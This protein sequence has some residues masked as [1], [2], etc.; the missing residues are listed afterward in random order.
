MPAEHRLRL[1]R[2]DRVDK[3]REHS[4]QQNQYQPIEVAAA[5]PEMQTCGLKSA[6]ADAEPGSR[7][8]FAPERETRSYDEQELGQES[9]HR[10]FQWHSRPLTSRRIGF[11]VGTTH[12]SLNKRAPL[13]RPRQTVGNR[14]RSWVGS[15]IYMFGFEFSVTTGYRPQFMVRGPV[16]G[17]SAQ[18]AGT[19]ISQ[20][21]DRESSDGSRRVGCDRE[22]DAHELW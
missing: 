21:S 14:F 18:F 1:D 8:A 17:A 6:P 15:I 13:F 9:R 2:G 19:G 4:I 11:S 22:S 20:A 10:A 12:S 5:E 3:R 7:P 16:P